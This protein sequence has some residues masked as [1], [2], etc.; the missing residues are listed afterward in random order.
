MTSVRFRMTFGKQKSNLFLIKVE[1]D[2]FSNI[3][4]TFS[5]VY[6]CQHK[7][8]NNYFAVKILPINDVVRHKQVQHVKNE[9]TVLQVRKSLIVDCWHVSGVYHVIVSMSYDVDEGNNWVTW[10]LNDAL[11]IGK[12]YV[13][14]LILILIPF[15]FNLSSSK[16]GR[17]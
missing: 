6:L 8:Q 12:L 4:G 3:P 10:H 1:A 14:F 5:R 7:K 13:S 15:V 2:W 11:E 17:V 9:K 16:F